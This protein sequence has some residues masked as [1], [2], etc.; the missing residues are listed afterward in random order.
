M[1]QI[2]TQSLFVRTRTQCRMKHCVKLMSNTKLYAVTNQNI[3]KIGSATMHACI[4][5]SPA[6]RYTQA[7]LVMSR[8]RPIYNQ[9]V[10]EP[11]KKRAYLSCTT[12]ISIFK[13][14]HGRKTI[15]SHSDSWRGSCS[16]L[17]ALLLLHCSV[18]SA[19]SLW[20]PGTASHAVLRQP[21]GFHL[22][23]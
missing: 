5:A 14:N 8:N 17:L 6:T 11:R 10:E 21:E 2:S 3:A 20:H 19:I 9:A 18:P 1:F 12:I 23:G 4:H 7:A 22:N 15:T 16:P 13:Y